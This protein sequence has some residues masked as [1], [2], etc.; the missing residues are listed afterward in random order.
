M[1]NLG[2]GWLFGE[3]MRAIDEATK[4]WEL[5]FI[6][7]GRNYTEGFLLGFKEARSP[8]GR[9]FRKNV[10]CEVDARVLGAKE[11]LKKLNK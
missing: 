9:W 2:A 6:S 8:F 7:R 11:T 4:K 3:K 10:L 5:H 1:F